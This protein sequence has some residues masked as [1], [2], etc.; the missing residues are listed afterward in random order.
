MSK[1]PEKNMTDATAKQASQATLYADR[2]MVMM[3]TLTI[4]PTPKHFSV[5]YSCAA[6]QPTELVREVEATAAKKSHFTD[7]YLD[8]LY[9]NYI[10]EAQSRAVRDTAQ[11]AKRILADIIHN[12]S[13]FAGNT[14]LVSQGVSQQ[15]QQLQQSEAVSEEMVR[16]LANSLVESATSM[17]HSSKTIG[18][19]LEVAQ[20]EISDLREKLARVVTE[21]ERDFLTGSYNRKAFDKRLHDAVED[22]N[23]HDAA[24]TLLMLDIDHFKLF[25]DS[26]GHLIGDEVLKL[27]ARTLNET[28]KGM[29]CVARY[30]GEEFAI[31][32]PRTSLDN[33]LIVAEAIRKAIASKELKRKATQETYGVVTASIGVAAFRAHQD[34]PEA[35]IARAD[36]ALY[37]SKHQGRNRVSAEESRSNVA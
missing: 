24:L 15:L 7:E 10:A 25:N 37:S 20:K 34:T 11:N 13:A 6:G 30:G 16:M 8:L 23:A 2:A 9:T 36:A 14:S 21:S 19:R 29:D 4:A 33:A 1:A 28:L 18:V 5:F 32:L 22:A 35:L 26:H 12:V 3:R 31:I 27:V 17:E